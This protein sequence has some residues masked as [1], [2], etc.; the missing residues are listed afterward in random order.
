MGNGIGQAA[1]TLK[2]ANFTEM[3]SELE[4][5]GDDARSI[6]AGKNEV[7]TNKTGWTVASNVFFGIGKFIRFCFGEKG[8]G[9]QAVKDAINREFGAQLKQLGHTNAQKSFGD[10]VI[11]TVKGD[12]NANLSV[13]DLAKIEQE[14]NKRMDMLPKQNPTDREIDASVRTLTQDQFQLGGGQKVLKGNAITTLVNALQNPNLDGD[15]RDH[16]ANAL[17]NYFSDNVNKYGELKNGIRIEYLT[18]EGAVKSGDMDGKVIK[19]L[20]AATNSEGGLVIPKSLQQELALSTAKHEMT[21]DK[22]DMSN[23]PFR[24]ATLGSKFMSAALGGLDNGVIDKMAK[25]ITGD[26]AHGFLSFEEPPVNKSADPIEYKRQYN[27]EIKAATT[28]AMTEIKQTLKNVASGK[29][30][31]MAETQQFLSKFEAIVDDANKKDNVARGYDETE[32]RKGMMSGKDASLNL[33]LLRGVNATTKDA[34]KDYAQKSITENKIDFTKLSTEVTKTIQV[35]VNA[36][37]GI[38]RGNEIQADD[39]AADLNNSIEMTGFKQ[40]IGYFD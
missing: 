7:W 34:S 22:Y 1:S 21:A 39:L 19:Q 14:I 31:N 32:M 20:F 13:G 35:A 10:D 24:N 15:K 18:A 36:N 28:G 23:G 30:G 8:K 4:K 3:K 11:K 38:D 40:R 26:I 2:T 33:F 17:Q 27:D 12:S 29:Y 6:R 25:D 37:V 5:T 9:N 16:I